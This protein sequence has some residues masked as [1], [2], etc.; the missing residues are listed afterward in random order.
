MLLRRENIEW[1]RVG[2]HTIVFWK[3][4]KASIIAKSKN[5]I[6]FFEEL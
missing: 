2:M 4:S 6:E 5:I 3:G 1:R